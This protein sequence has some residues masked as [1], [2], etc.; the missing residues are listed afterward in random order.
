MVLQA[1]NVEKMGEGVQ[2]R[3]L[4]G[5]KGRHNLCAMLQAH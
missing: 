2:E 1:E 3:S 5:I 4:E